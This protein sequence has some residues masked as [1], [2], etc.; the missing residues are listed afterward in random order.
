M[1]L[2]LHGRHS[3][4]VTLTAWQIV[5]PICK[6]LMGQ[7]RV[8]RHMAVAIKCKY[9][10]VNSW[11]GLVRVITPPSLPVLDITTYAKG[12]PNSYAFPQH[13]VHGACGM[14]NLKAAV[15]NSH[16]GCTIIAAAN[17]SNM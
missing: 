4:L 14:W 9:G 13:L 5:L 2:L 3:C 1:A 12:K 10:L 7:N 11:E 8:D 6:A 17:S 16:P 15:S